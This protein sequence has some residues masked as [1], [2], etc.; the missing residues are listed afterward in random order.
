MYTLIYYPANLTA[1]TFVV[2][3][4]VHE[5]AAGAFAGSNLKSMAIPEQI[6]VIADSAF[7]SSALESVAFHKGITTIGDYAFADCKNLNHVRMLNSITNLGNYVF[8][9]C[10]GLSDFTFEEVPVGGNPYIM[11]THFFDGCT[12]ITEV[13]LPNSMRLSSETEHGFTQKNTDLTVAIPAYMFANTG[14]VHAVIPARILNMGSEGVFY[15][16]KALENVTFEAWKLNSVPFGAYFFYGCSKIKELVVPAG[17]SSN[18]G[19]NYAFAY[20]TA[21][22]KFVM[23]ASPTLNANRFEGCI[24]L[25]IFEAWTVNTYEED[26]VGNIIGYAKVTQTSIGQISNNALKG[27]TS[28]KYLYL[29]NSYFVLMNNAA[30]AG[31]SVETVVLTNLGMVISDAIF[32]GTEN[33][34]NV[35]LGKTTGSKVYKN[36]F[37]DLD[38]D[39]NFYFYEQTKEEVIAARGE[40]WLTNADEKAH[41]YFKDTIPAD[42]EWPEEIKPAE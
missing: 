33:L 39:M 16:C 14:I 6:T 3:E 42:V 8:A 15:N 1:E 17:I 37:T 22:E 36:M 20:C 41:F 31:S 4:T 34:K 29:C 28:L 27:L 24:N 11:G 35:W 38:T 12:L 18:L 19:G 40:D 9:N 7:Q 5:F 10:T 25:K 2:P 30:F 26:E 21:L 23:Y 13:I 32:G